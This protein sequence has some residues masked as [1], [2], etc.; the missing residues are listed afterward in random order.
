MKQLRRFIE[1]KHILLF[2]IFALTF[3]GFRGFNLNRYVMT[4]E[5][6]WLMRS[7]NFY[8]ALGQRD[9][10]QT[11]QKLDPAVTTMWTNTAAF[12][13]VAPQYRGLGQG[14]FDSYTSFDNYIQKRNIDP[15]QVLIVGRMI[16]VLENLIILL[17]AFKLMI[18][19]IGLI[20]T[21][22]AF[23][24][25]ALDP[26]H[27]ALTSVSHT[28]G[29]LS[30]LML[31]SI[32]S[33][34]VYLLYKPG[35][36]YV[37]ISAAAASLTCLTKLPGYLLFPF[38]FCCVIIDAIQKNKKKSTQDADNVKKAR[39]KLIRD[40]FLWF[41]VFVIIYVL[42][43]PA[44]WVD[45]IG[46]VALQVNAPF[47]FLQLVSRSARVSPIETTAS[48]SALMFE[49][50]KDYITFYPNRY[51]WHTTPIAMAGIVLLVIFSI[52]RKKPNFINE[53]RR[54]IGF[55]GLFVLIFYLLLSLVDKSSSRYFIPAIVV[56]DIFSA[57]GWVALFQTIFKIEIKPLKFIL[58][59]TIIFAI[60][61]IS[62]AENISVYPYFFS[63]YNPVMGA[64]NKA[65]IT[66][67]VG[68]GEGLDQAGQYLSQKPNASKLTVMSWYAAGCLSYYFPGTTVEIAVADIEESDYVVVYTT[69]WRRRYPSNLFD[70]LDKVEPEKTIWLNNVEYV[71]IYKVED[72]PKELLPN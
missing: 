7:G 52:I 44:M 1:N 15:H 24:M 70:I 67:A 2:I 69:Q 33:F 72:I 17:V 9:F 43:W 18:H 59:G 58:A 40:I 32:I 63:Y 8:Y 49:K 22:S 35:W 46:T 13:I 57:F 26:F 31:L 23:M 20:P 42:V 45:P 39:N 27:I 12:L 30:S 34:L 5:T 53:N 21:F 48:G 65:G 6:P 36:F 54:V 11:R 10:I 28:D 38:F 4:D 71:R 64:I 61:A 51:L 60:L 41:A 50:I 62:V 3:V 14:Y 56:L 25:I 55:L 16:M 66:Q 19:I 29:L 47:H 68:S 37:V